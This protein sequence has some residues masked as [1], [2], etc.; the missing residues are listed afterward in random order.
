MR[1]GV[2]LGVLLLLIAVAFRLHGFADG[3]SSVCLTPPEET[4]L[5]DSYQPVSLYTWNVAPRGALD[6]L[7]G[8]VSP[9]PLVTAD[10]APLDRFAL[11]LVSLASGVLALAILLRLGRGLRANWGWLAVL[12]AAVAP[13]FV[14][15]DRWT[16]R[17][18][19]ALFAVAVSLLALWMSSRIQPGKWRSLAI[20]VQAAAALSLLVIA[21]PLWWLALALL[22]VQPY[23]RW[24]WALF[25]LL[26]GGVL[27]P[28]L[29][30]PE[31]WLA[32]VRTWDVSAT[33]TCA[34]VGLVLA[35][36][37]RRSLP[38]LAQ[39]LLLAAALLLGAVTLYEDSQ[40]V[41]PTAAEWQL[42][43]WLQARTPDDAVVQFDSAT[44]RL[45]SIV[46]CPV[47]AN[48]RFTAQSEVVQFF[49]VRELAEPYYLVSADAATVADM[50]YVTQVSDQFWVGRSLALKQPVDVPFGEWVYL[51][52]YEVLTPAARPSGL[53]DVRIDYQF[54]ANITPDVLAY[55]A[56]VHLTPSGDPA[57]NWVNITD[58]FFAESGNT[59]SRRVMLNHHIR[60]SLPP[61]IPPGTYD[62]RYGIYNQSTG[63]RLGEV[64]LGGVT[65]E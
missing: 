61:D 38:R 5:Y 48:L 17:F 2:W 24:R 3:L 9:A 50:P 58:P 26:S 28:A 23:P 40:R 39:A 25:I 10:T 49:D 32:A 27:V 54:G 37:W 19:P 60:F 47:G 35:L 8:R 29:Q 53:V 51:L 64:V 42:V 20:I 33:A 12:L 6:S 16:V 43:G 62:V 59:G 46:A 1:R 11:R 31:L 21:P 7:P 44:W 57:T 14:A 22:L 30:T 45:A 56:Y 15:A 36:W 41:T 65:V 18:D 4:W 55:A 13:W 34:F 63:E 52:S